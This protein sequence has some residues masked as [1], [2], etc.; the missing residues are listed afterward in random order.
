MFVCFRGCLNGTVTFFQYDDAQNKLVTI[1]TVRNDEMSTSL[2]SL[3]TCLHVSLDNYSRHVA[4]AT[5]SGFTFRAAYLKVWR[6]QD[7]TEFDVGHCGR[8]EKRCSDFSISLNETF[9]D[10]YKKKHSTARV[11]I[12]VCST[13]IHQRRRYRLSFGGRGG[14]GFWISIIWS[15]GELGVGRRILNM[16]YQS[17]FYDRGSEIPIL[18]QLINIHI[19]ILIHRKIKYIVNI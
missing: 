19:N 15:S 1:R 14:I 11:V 7:S 10:R 17:K 16:L 5:V 12:K 6:M 18:Y 4:V 9:S 3:I 13:P 8:N 2:M